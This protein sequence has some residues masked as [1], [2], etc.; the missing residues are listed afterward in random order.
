[1]RS[2]PHGKLAFVGRVAAREPGRGG[3][4][5]STRF[6]VIKV[7][8]GAVP[9]EVVTHDDAINRICGPT[10]EIGKAYVVVVVETPHGYSVPPCTMP[11][12]DVSQ[13]TLLETARR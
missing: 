4:R 12:Q 3:S 5:D 7:L 9:Q 10:F 8:A 13:G 1:M 6:D 11:V 2:P